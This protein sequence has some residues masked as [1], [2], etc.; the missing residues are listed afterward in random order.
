MA[1]SF[2]MRFQIGGNLARSF[3][4]TFSRA[5]SSLTGLR[6]QS[7]QTQRA[8]DQLGNEFRRGAIHQTQYAESTERLTRELQ[9][10]ERAQR[11]ISTMKTMFSNGL[12]TA[13]QVAGIAAV[14]TV[15]VATGL[16]LNSVNKAADF[17]K[18]ITKVGVIADASASDVKRLNNTALELGASTSLSSSEVAVAMKEL[19]SKG[20]DTNKIIGSMP[21]ILSA[22]EASGEDLAMTSNVVVSALNAFGLKAT[23]AGHVADVMAM[24]AN[25]SAA[26]VEDLG[27]S[28]KY[29]AP[30]AKTLGISLEELA[31]STGI[32][33]DKGLSGE[34]AGTSL[35]MA[36]IR[37][38][39][40]PKA[41]RKAL[42]ALNL[43]ATDSHKNFKSLTQI[44]D[45][46]N[47][48]TKK[49][50]QTQKVKYAADVFGV[51]AATGML[52]L[53][54]AGPKKINE[55]TKALE[56]STGSAEK[57]AHAMKDNY[58]GSLDQLKGSIES[59]Q[60]KFA[61]PILPVFKDV[62]DGLG[63][64]LTKNMGGIEEAG[65]KTAAALRD[66]FD[67]FTTQKPTFDH[68]NQNPDYKDYYRKELAKYNKFSGMDFGDKVVY[69]L[70]EATKKI[71]EWLSGSG[72]DSMNKIFTKLG[73]IAAKAWL[74]AF[75]GAVKSTGSNLMQ[76]NFAAAGGMGTLAW[77]MGGGL[78]V[79][80]AFSASKWGYG[81][82][83]GRGARAATVSPEASVTGGTAAQSITPAPGGRTP[84]R[85]ARGRGARGG[86]VTGQRMA[87][88]GTSAA[89]TTV[90]ATSATS[91]SSR[92]LGVLG[93]V[94]KVAGKAALPVSIALEGYNIYK[95]QDKTKATVQAAGGIGGGW[96]GAAAGAAIGTAIA[97]VIGTA[98][99]GLIGGIGGYV[100]GKWGGGKVVDAARSNS[101]AAQ[102]VPSGSAIDTT[103]ANNA[104][105]ALVSNIQLASNNFTLLTMYSGQASGWIAGSFT[106]IKTSA[107]LVKGN[108]DILT[109][110]TGQASGWM[111]SLNGIQTAGQ[112]VIEALNRLESRINSVKLPSPS[113]RVSYDG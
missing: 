55:M 13:K 62:F 75:E 104:T 45:E 50:T 31:S 83:K 64:T 51:E 106:G 73:E 54:S 102:P 58:A 91:T 82:F 39:K 61:T 34:Q 59:A 5:S 9:Q 27:Y 93:K 103:A 71:E 101:A 8:L 20:F 12:N 36:L 10:L 72:G 46:W 26:G 79:K 87:T 3:S 6:N 88:A 22:A 11:R 108:L 47:K 57:A 17:E 7:R 95:A 109:S 44:S 15:A 1:R 98:I 48:A 37:L 43:S 70:D 40:P 68:T 16:A 42:D 67:P 30:V 78:A 81:K 53:F 33:V 105:Q 41:A 76:G 65:K 14:G 86:R 92:A 80:G 2:E 97:P 110:Y 107:D 24:S 69:S 38:A 89:T 60:I 49:L 52:N 111:A 63:S 56:N 100:A 66:I 85:P 19:A 74:A 77:L 35:R 25:K 90:E 4:S 113:K 18:Q 84:A 29:A 28:F 112:R 21:G 23:Q 99:G 96:A 32:M 94:G